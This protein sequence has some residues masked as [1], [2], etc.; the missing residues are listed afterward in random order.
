MANIKISFTR[1]CCSINHTCVDCDG[2]SRCPGLSLV[3]DNT[4][5]CEHLY[6]EDVIAE[7]P[8]CGFTYQSGDQNGKGGRFVTKGIFC[9][10]LSLINYLEINGKVIVDKEADDE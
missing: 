9:T 1:M 8:N 5:K 2:T 10:D 7:L 4:T 6:Y 3:D